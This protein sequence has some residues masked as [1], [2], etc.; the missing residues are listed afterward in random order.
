MIKMNDQG[1]SEFE[2]LIN[3][4]WASEK[5]FA[6]LVQSDRYPQK[7]PY[8]KKRLFQHH[9]FTPILLDEFYAVQGRKPSE[10]EFTT[11][12]I[13]RDM[14][15][16]LLEENMA[17]LELDTFLI[18]KEQALIG[19]YQSVLANRALPMTTKALL[20]SQA[21]VLNGYQQERLLDYRILHR[22]KAM[23]VY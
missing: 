2:L 19:V 11:S 1:Y 6:T 15:K 4:L 21:E 18:E 9:H 23:D 13:F 16:R 12:P 7:Q 14:E 10:T 5:A 22:S 3:E 20:Q 8:F 17:D